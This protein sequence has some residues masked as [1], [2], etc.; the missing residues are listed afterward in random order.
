MVVMAPLAQI[1][2]KSYFATMTV[3][4]LRFGISPG[5]GIVPPADSTLR[6]LELMRELNV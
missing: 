3:L 2:A 1:S 5:A 4:A 6:G